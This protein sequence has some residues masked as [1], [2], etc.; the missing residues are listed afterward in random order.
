M[1]VQVFWIPDSCKL[2]YSILIL[3]KSCVGK[4]LY[5]YIIAFDKLIVYTVD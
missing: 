1:S 4:L 5:S 3:V 2:L